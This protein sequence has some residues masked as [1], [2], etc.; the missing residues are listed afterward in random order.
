M[1]RTILAATA[2]VLCPG[3]VLWAFTDGRLPFEGIEGNPALVLLDPADV[4]PPELELVD[5]Q[6]VSGGSGIGTP[7]IAPAIVPGRT[8]YSFETIAQG[9]YSGFGY[10]CQVPATAQAPSITPVPVPNPPCYAKV[11]QPAFEA[12]IRDDCTWI[13]FWNEHASNVFPPPPPPSVDFD[14]YAVIAV[15]S[16]SRSNGCYGME[17]RSVTKEK[18]GVVVRVRERVPCAGELCTLALTN[19]FHFVKICKSLVPFKSRVCFEHNNDNVL[20]TI[21]ILCA[22]PVPQAQVR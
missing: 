19:N 11:A 12:V 21:G 16:G 22:S 20:C 6:A 7:T 15:V 10:Y 2:A 3:A 1:K 5:A 9:Q 17:V 8:C 14:K 18:C 4:A 13:D